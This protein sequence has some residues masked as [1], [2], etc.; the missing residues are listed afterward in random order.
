MAI[1][2]QPLT[3]RNLR[4]RFRQR[5]PGRRR[6]RLQ[7]GIPEAEGGSTRITQAD[8]TA[9]V[10]TDDADDADAVAVVHAPI[11]VEVAPLLSLSPKGRP[12]GGS[13]HH[14]MAGSFGVHRKVISRV[15]ATPSSHHIS[16]GSWDYVAVTPFRQP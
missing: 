13:I 15:Q 10:R 9:S 7:H 4:L 16:S 12:K 6:V 5:R 8:A 3:L 2:V 1:P 14:A 11:M